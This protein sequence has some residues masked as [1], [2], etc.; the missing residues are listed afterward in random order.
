MNDDSVNLNNE[1]SSEE[2]KSPAGSSG[3][4]NSLSNSN[5]SEE[6]HKPTT[7]VGAVSPKHIATGAEDDGSLIKSKL[8]SDGSSKG[9]RFKKARRKQKSQ[10]NLED[11][12]F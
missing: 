7:T 4:L 1:S 9:R 12:L 2:D 10:L 11:L 3:G 6:E 5:A 8:C